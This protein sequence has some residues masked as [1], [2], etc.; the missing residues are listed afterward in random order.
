MTTTTYAT[1]TIKVELS[2]GR[3]WEDQ[4]LVE[5]T[6]ADGDRVPHLR[7]YWPTTSRPRTTAI[8]PYLVNLYKQTPSVLR[9]WV[10]ADHAALRRGVKG[11]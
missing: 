8:E 4:I 5:I 11:E 3:S 2:S 7:S 9:D 10:D 1:V 6:K